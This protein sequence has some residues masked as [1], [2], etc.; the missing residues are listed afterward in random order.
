MHTPT[1]D[2]RGLPQPLH[3]NTDEVSSIGHGG[4]LTTVLTFDASLNSPR[5]NTFLCLEIAWGRENQHTAP[6]AVTY[7]RGGGPMSLPI[8]QPLFYFWVVYFTTMF[9]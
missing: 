4:L 5:T 2:F 3:V 9:Q 1:D 7:W 8:T 6:A